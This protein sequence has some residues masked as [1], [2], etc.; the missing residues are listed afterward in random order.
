MAQLPL[1]PGQVYHIMN[2]ANAEGKLFFEE[3]NYAYFQELMSEHLIP[4]YDILAF[5]LLPKH[6]HVLV[7]LKDLPN[8]TPKWI[9]KPHQPYANLCNA[10]AKAINKT[11][12]RKGSLFSTHPKRI[13]IDSREKMKDA[14]VYIHINAQKHGLVKNY[15]DYRHSSFH[16][17]LRTNL[18][19]VNTTLIQK[20]IGDENYLLLHEQRKKKML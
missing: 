15:M 18:N 20:A 9:H 10:Y 5:A 2:N 1:I 19:F 16:H 17:Y 4:H 13:H 7:K 14:L 3:E 8:F 6:F 12:R 11:Y